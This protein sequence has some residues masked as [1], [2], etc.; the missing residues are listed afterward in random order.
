[1]SSVHA[2]EKSFVLG[3]FPTPEAL[4][5][6]G[7]KLRPLA[8]GKLDA[9]SPYPVHGI[10]EAIGIPRSIVPRIALTGGLLGAIGG[11]GLIVFCN[12]IDY[13]INIGGRPIHSWPANIPITFECGI[14][15]TALSIFFGCMFLFG[16]PRPYHPVFECEAFRSASIDAFWIG[17]ESDKPPSELGEVAAKLREL[18]ARK[19]EI[20]RGPT[21]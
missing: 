13:P 11:Y 3:E 16:L 17:V 1:M 12:V 4:V 10:D 5:E 18:G 19:V 14:L 21:A 8:L 9:Y 20:V 7:A 15:F 6:A 2:P